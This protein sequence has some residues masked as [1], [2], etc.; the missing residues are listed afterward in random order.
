MISLDGIKKILIVRNDNIGDVILTTP[1]VEA[2]RK[3]Y[4][5]AY[6]AILVA[7][8]AREAIEGN[9]YLDKIYSY[10]KA[11]HSKGNKFMALWRQY[12]VIKEIRKDKFD[13]AIGIRSAFSPSQGWL[14]FASGAPLR[15]GHYPK[16]KRYLS[17]LYNI[18]ADE[19]AD[20]THE[21]IRAL[22][23]LKRIDVDPELVSGER[24]ELFFSVPEE[25]KV[26]VRGFIER[27]GL[28]KSKKLICLHIS[29]RQEE[30]RW[31]DVKNYIAL[32]DSL[33]ERK[34]IDL[35][36]NWPPKEKPLA[37]EILSKAK[38]QPLI[39]IS[40]GIKSLAAFLRECNIFITLDGGAMHI[41]TAVNT[42][43]IA[44]FGKTDTEVWHPWGEG[45][46]ALKRGDN[47]N[48]VTVEDVTNAVNKIMGET[49]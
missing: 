32:A 23:I 24:K 22:N 7:E 9:P 1:A 36:L 33:I 48:S 13:L 12:K 11:K 40:K 46:I 49:S 20:K 39:F 21:V 4:P 6:I 8:Y 28:K 10:Q 25:E 17:F 45:H 47:Y 15:L 29:K 2:L 5:D 26:N 44:I 38:K 35:V 18:Y 27:N 31:W 37:E 41:A 43:T 16:E 14:V 30:G 42:P 3:C 34:D 19:I